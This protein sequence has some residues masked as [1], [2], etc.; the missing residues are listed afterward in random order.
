MKRRRGN[1][2]NSNSR[3]NKYYYNSKWKLKG[4]NKKWNRRM[5]SAENTWLSSRGL[6]KYNQSRRGLRKKGKYLKQGNVK[7]KF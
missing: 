5:K 3:Q 2:K 7:K 1:K 6:S 4:R